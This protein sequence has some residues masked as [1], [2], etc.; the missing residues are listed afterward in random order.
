MSGNTVQKTRVGVL[1]DPP[2]A[3]ELENASW[4]DEDAVVEVA[5]HLPGALERLLEVQPEAVVA[6]GDDAFIGRIASQYEFGANLKTRPLRLYPAQTAG[7]SQLAGALG[8]KD[9]S[10]RLI[11]QLVKR[12]GDARLRRTQVR[13]LKVVVSS[14]PH[15][16]LGFSFGAGI[17]YRLFEAY[18]RA[19]TETSGRVASTLFGLARD[20]LLE[21]GRNLDPVQAKLS[22]DGQPYAEAIGYL[23][24]SSLSKTWLGL[25]MDADGASAAYR[26]G[27]RGRELIKRVASSRALPSFA[28]ADSATGFERLDVDWSSGFVLDGELVEPRGPHALRVE[29]GPS[30]DCVTL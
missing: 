16:R 18:K 14:E 20:T 8:N 3:S 25:S 17:F 4:R 11:R 28:R 21:G 26:V 6:A 22:I 7:S 9:F 29:P 15:A 10:P 27:E 1:V 2:F 24:C 30:I 19:Q 12:A 23:V 13:T 5:D